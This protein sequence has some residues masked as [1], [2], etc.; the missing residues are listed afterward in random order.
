MKG[1]PCGS[2]CALVHVHRLS[3]VSEN[4]VQVHNNDLYHLLVAYCQK[5]LM[6]C[7]I[8]MMWK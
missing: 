7:M 2:D 6:F 3:A 1:I 8:C 5:V 4:T